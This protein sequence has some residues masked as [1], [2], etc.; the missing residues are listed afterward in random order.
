MDEIRRPQTRFPVPR[1]LIGAVVLI[2]AVE[3]QLGRADLHLLD[4]G[5]ANHRFPATVLQEA[6]ASGA[7]ILCFGDSL[8][9]QG[10]VPRV[11]EQQLGKRVYNL[12][13]GGGTPAATYCM[14]RRAL[15]AGAHPSAVIVDFEPVMISIGANHSEN[16]LAEAGTLRDCVDVG[17]N[18]R[19][20]LYSG[21]LASA[22]V[23][24]SARYRSELRGVIASALAGKPAR[25]RESVTQA[26]NQWRVD[27][28]VHIN[29]ERQN[30]PGTGPEWNDRYA[31]HVPRKCDWRS[32]RYVA[33]FLALADSKAIPVYWVLPPAHPEVQANWDAGGATEFYTRF[34]RGMKQRFPRLTVIDA[35]R[36]GYPP[37]RFFDSCHLDGPGALSFTA[38]L[39]EALSQCPPHQVAQ[40]GWVSIAGDR[41]EVLA[42]SPLPD[43]RLR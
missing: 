9:K 39:G 31:R 43:S 16:L 42:T 26:W 27:R 19:S 37:Q 32:E 7:E 6:E 13:I 4:L 36:S 30:G 34:V 12:A 28:G 33:R 40:G 8:V 11:L 41:I 38:R 23:L 24:T 20:A 21:T 5:A 3:F 29:P 18:Y 25:T 2:A 14:F 15:D 35:R 17:W 1:G 10:V 22:W